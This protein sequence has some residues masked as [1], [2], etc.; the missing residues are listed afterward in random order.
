[1]GKTRS[2]IDKKNSTTY[3]LTWGTAG[4]DG[5]DDNDSVAP[6]AVSLAGSVS[7]LGSAAP[8]RQR[9]GAAS[10]YE[11]EYGSEWG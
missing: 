11:S 7:E 4:A 9:G 6:D 1:M 3:T 5:G 2:F 8:S 10:V